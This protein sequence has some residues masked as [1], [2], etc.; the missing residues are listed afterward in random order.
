MSTPASGD[1]TGRAGRQ[2]AHALDGDPVGE[3]AVAA[4]PGVSH[5]G[6][7]RA[8]QVPEALSMQ[9]VSSVAEQRTRKVIGL[10]ALHG[11]HDDLEHDLDLDV[12]NV[13]VARAHKSREPGSAFL[14]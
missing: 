12:S 7:E 3:V 13:A 9:R 2:A 8:S 14:G 10:A 11:L 5:E 4:G 1:K 6:K